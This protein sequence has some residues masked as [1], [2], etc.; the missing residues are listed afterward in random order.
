MNQTQSTDPHNPNPL[1]VW[2]GLALGFGVPLLVIM[3]L[4]ALLS[5]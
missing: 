5:Y 3:F 2:L 4:S 1:P